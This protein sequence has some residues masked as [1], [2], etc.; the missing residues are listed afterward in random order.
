MPAHRLVEEKNLIPMRKI[1]KVVDAKVVSSLNLYIL[2]NDDTSHD[3]RPFAL[4]ENVRTEEGHEN[5]GYA[6]ELLQEAIAVARSFGCYKLILETSSKRQ[7]V[8]HLYDK[9][10]F[11]KDYKTAYYMKL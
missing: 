3:C 2:E 11:V 9:A 7:N 6:S 8:H 10:G 4:I 1:T 5:R